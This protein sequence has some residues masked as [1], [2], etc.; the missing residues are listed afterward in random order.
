MGLIKLSIPGVC[1]KK[2]I[3]Y[4]RF[5]VK[6]SDGKWG[7]IYVR[8]PDPTDPGFA[9][10]LARV[11]AAPVSAPEAVMPG[12]MAA[13]AVEFRAAL[14]KGWTKKTR[15]KGAKALAA[16]TLVN[17][18]RYVELIREEH[19]KKLVADIRPKHIYKL[20]DDMADKPGKANNYLNVLKLMLHF[21]V[22]R[23]WRSDNPA[24]AIPLL[25]IGEHEPW[26][27]SVL[28]EALEAASPML[29]LAIVTGLCSGQ[30]ISDVIL[31][32]HGW[33]KTGI[34]ELSQMKTAVD[35]AVPIHP[36]WRTEIAKVPKQAVTILYDRS[37]K[38]FAS[39]DRIQERI[40]RLM[41]DL[42][43]VDAEGQLLYTFHGL[44]KNACCYLLELGLSDTDVGA[45][46]GMTPETVRHYGKR[47]R[48]YMI[49]QGAA[50]KVT[51][52]K[53]FALRGELRAASPKKS[54]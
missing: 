2:G 28:E 17:Y 7:D 45:I 54:S 9:E 36:W 5:R 19:G 48:A 18:Q 43:H 34:M 51:G 44:R 21:A 33:L 47:A 35:V 38:P 3:T 53:L 13:L 20:R 11:N 25:P 42:G 50:G 52:G 1:Q 49:A 24:A 15:K 26:P 29:R 12:T 41:H 30:R 10:A 37:G 8:L 23:D 4:R 39:E 40:R 16:N 22:E 32:Q 46:L 6:Q 14:V 27:A 31:I